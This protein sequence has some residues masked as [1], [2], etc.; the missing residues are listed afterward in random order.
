MPL[1]PTYKPPSGKDRKLE[2][3]G[4]YP[5]TRGIYANMY[6]GRLWTMRQ[7]AGF[8]TAPEWNRRYYY[9]LQQGQTD[10]SIAFDLPTQMGMDPDRPPG[11]G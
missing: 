6:R 11:Q 3:P 1:K 8:G 9:L 4:E 10:L 2:P 7:Y 5:C